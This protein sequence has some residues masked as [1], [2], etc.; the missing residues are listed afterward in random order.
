M[1][2]HLQVSLVMLHSIMQVGSGQQ[3]RFVT[4][5][6]EVSVSHVMMTVGREG[7]HSQYLLCCIAVLREDTTDEIEDKTVNTIIEIIF[8]TKQT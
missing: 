7:C 1:R 2:V 3:P 8:A 5:E 6:T 4:A